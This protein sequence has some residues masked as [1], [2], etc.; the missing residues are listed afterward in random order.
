MGTLFFTS[1]TMIRLFVGV[2]EMENGK[3]K[4]DPNGGVIYQTDP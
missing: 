3:V 1:R 2:A 4:T